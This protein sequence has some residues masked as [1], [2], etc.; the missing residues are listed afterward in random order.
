MIFVRTEKGSQK[1]E[2]W[3]EIT[4]RPRFIGQI[5]K[6]EHT[7]SEIIG[8]YQFKNEIHCGLKGCNQPHQRGYLVRTEDGIE[9]NIGKVCGTGEFGI[10]FKELTGSF[11][12]F[13]DLETNKMAISEAKQKCASWSA[14]IEGLRKS[15]PSINTCA[16]NIEK[17]QNANYAGRLAA[18]EIR[19]LAKSQNGL[20][21]LTE[22]ETSKLAREI[23]FSADKHMR[24][25]GE[26]TSDYIIG[27][28]SFT[29]VL[30]PENNLKERFISISDDI[31][32]IHKISLESA[33]SPTIA[34][35]A[36]RAN[37]LEDRIKQLKLL[38]HEAVKF[39]NI[40]NLSA[41]SN[42]LKYSS[43]APES[44][45]RSFETFLR[46]LNRK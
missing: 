33:S 18:A 44:E 22:V 34:D 7:L 28:V 14:T 31:K 27:K 39:L 15:K 29:N 5:S 16:S 40:K 32:G 38:L 26:A 1:V 43:T 20:V 4:N 46:T 8:F 42:K 17:I 30:L 2:C 3:E 24:E 23:L 9:T 6:A 37:T 13:M 11:H 35:I 36:R 12:K 41:I 21:K 25:S 45:L 10:Q 19:L